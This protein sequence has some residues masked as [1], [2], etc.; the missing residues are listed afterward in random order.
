MF[1]VTVMI[2]ENDDIIRDITIATADVEQLREDTKHRFKFFVV[3]SRE[4]I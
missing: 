4:R 2:I 1:K 3:E